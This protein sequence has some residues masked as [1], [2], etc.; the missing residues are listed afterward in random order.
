MGTQTARKDSADKFVGR[1]LD[2]RYS[3]ESVIEV[4]GMGT[5]Y[6]GTHIRLGRQIAV[7]ILHEEL[8]GDDVQ[9]ERFL[10]EARAAAEIHHR[11]VVDVIDIGT[12]KEGLPYFVMELLHGE[13]LK[14]RMK[15]L[16]ILAPAEIGWIIQQALAGL[17][18]AHDSGIIHRDVKPGNVFI[19]KEK[20]GQ[21]IAKILDFGV[22]K[23]KFRSEQVHAKELTTTGT[24]LG[25]PY[26]M[27]P[28]QAMGKKSMVDSRSD[29]YS[30]G[31]ILYRGLTGRNPFRGENYNEVIYN[32]L[33]L[34]VQPP[35][36]L[37]KKLPPEVDWIVMRAIAR[38]PDER[39]RKCQEFIDA[40]EPFKNFTAAGGFAGEKR[41]ADGTPGE[42]AREGEEDVAADSSQIMNAAVAGGAPL[43]G[44]RDAEEKAKLSA[45]V[46]LPSEI[47][48]RSW[49]RILPT[50][51]KVLL[52][53]VVLLAAFYGIW[54]Y[55][56]GKGNTTNPGVD[57]GRKKTAQAQ[58]GQGDPAHTV[59]TAS[60]D[61]LLTLKGV[62]E[63]ASVSVDDVVH[64]ERPLT[65]M[66]G[67]KPVAVEVAK[68]G[69]KPFREVIAPLQDA[70]IPVHMEKI[71]PPVV[72]KPPPAVEEEQTPSNGKDEKGVKKKKK[73]KGKDAKKKIYMTLPGSKKK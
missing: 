56:S 39:Y 70:E 29:I 28:E 27:S 1:V 5:V 46:T 38:S 19:S 71:E 69:F 12:T 45:M 13:A 18:V 52:A 48:R 57:P 20:D 4:G 31:L 26:Y 54:E 73:K 6:E 61:V 16:R 49:K 41:M 64:P 34:D 10:R 24:I 25:T 17:S 72:E 11:N 43:P 32:I 51:A 22:A 3:I 47:G 65:V 9:A 44:G 37:N 21:E 63:G 7:K 33:T 8:V 59:K 40:L 60:S 68:E 23:F 58:A 30:C 14:V 55:R 62:P 36:F 2:S 50:Y 67:E 15:R 35:S 66:R 42:T 53:I